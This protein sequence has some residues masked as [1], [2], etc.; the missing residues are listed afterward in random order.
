MG[1]DLEH[2]ILLSAACD[3]QGL[4]V[5]PLLT[6]LLFVRGGCSREKIVLVREAINYTLS[7]VVV[8]FTS[9]GAAWIQGKASLLS[10]SMEKNIIFNQSFLLKLRFPFEFSL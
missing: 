2:H 4:G 10:L 1:K 6:L 7:E 5:N 9:R 8:V 3:R